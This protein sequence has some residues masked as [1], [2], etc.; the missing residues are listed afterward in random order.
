MLG[1]LGTLKEVKVVPTV[2]FY[3][4][5]LVIEIPVCQSVEH[6]RSNIIG[7]DFRVNNFAAITNYKR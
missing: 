6:D 1:S 3:T 2:G 7:I 4:V 5:Q